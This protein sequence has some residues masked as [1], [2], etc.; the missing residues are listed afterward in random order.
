MPIRDQYALWGR[1]GRVSGPYLHTGSLRRNFMTEVDWDRDGQSELVFGC[2]N[3]RWQKA[4]LLVL[5][6]MHLSGVSPP[7]DEELYV[8]SG[9]PRGSQRYYVAFPETELSEGDGVRNYVTTVK[10]DASS[11][12]MDVAVEEGCNFPF[13]G[14][15]LGPGELPSFHYI[16]DSQ[17]MPLGCSIIE[18]DNALFNSL[19]RSV[20]RDTISN[21]DEYLAKLVRETIVIRGDSVIFGSASTRGGFFAR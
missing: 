15:K 5:D 12:S 2:T 20:G 1:N 3:N 11:K 10:I 7:W 21:W 4:G 14:K 19:L 17:F 6:P 18:G 16:L 13:D 9:M 8:A